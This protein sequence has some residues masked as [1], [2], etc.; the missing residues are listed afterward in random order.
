MTA[1]KILSALT[2]IGVTIYI[3]YLYKGEVNNLISQQAEAGNDQNFYTE[4]I[5]Y[6]IHIFPFTKTFGT[7]LYDIKKS[8]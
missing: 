8:I 1:F 7:E 5:I 4:S 6:N 2:L 3:Y